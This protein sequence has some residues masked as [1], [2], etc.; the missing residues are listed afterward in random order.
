MN[1]LKFQSLNHLGHN[2]SKEHSTEASSSPNEYDSINDA[3]IQMNQFGRG[4]VTA[5]EKIQEND[6]NEEDEDKNGQEVESNVDTHPTP[7]NDAETDSAHEF[8]SQLVTSG[9]YSSL[10]LDR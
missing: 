4:S 6:N 3:D 9:N 7:V 8:Q 2:M 5:I 1:I 10:K